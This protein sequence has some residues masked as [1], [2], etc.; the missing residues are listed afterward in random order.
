MSSHFGGRAA[1]RSISWSWTGTDPF[2]PSNARPVLTSS[3]PRPSAPFARAFRRSRWSWRRCTTGRRAGLK[4]GSTYC[5][6]PRLW[7]DTSGCNAQTSSVSGR[8]APAKSVS[9]RSRASRQ[10]FAW[11]R[12]PIRR[13][14]PETPNPRHTPRPLQQARLAR[15]VHPEG[16]RSEVLMKPVDMTG[17]MDSVDTLRVP[18]VH[19]PLDSTLRVQSTCP[20][21]R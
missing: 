5:L 1:T 9:S 10:Q 7:N 14:R 16:K 6:G 4:P 3:A 8:A 21:G 12:P 11:Q 15:R 13:S 18:T 17:L 20:R 2:W 19:S